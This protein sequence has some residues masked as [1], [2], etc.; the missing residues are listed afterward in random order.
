MAAAGWR[1]RCAA[2]RPVGSLPASPPPFRIHSLSPSTSFLSQQAASQAPAK[3]LPPSQISFDTLSNFFEFM[4]NQRQRRGK[5]AAG[6]EKG[7][8]RLQVVQR[9][10]EA[11]VDKQSHDAFS[12]FRLML[13]AV[14]A[15][16]GPAGGRGPL[17]VL[18]L[19]RVV[20][21]RL[22]VTAM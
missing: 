22:Q 14:S 6:A 2:D 16:V 9:F 1:R 11:N 5:K 21:G 18:C 7:G 20:H 8:F 15:A 17:L 3:R 4:V 10:I 19:V 13:P 12:I